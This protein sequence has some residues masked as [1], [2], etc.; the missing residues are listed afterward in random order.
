MKD[1]SMINQPT[2]RIASKLVILMVFC[3]CLWMLSGRAS[4][5][6]QSKLIVSLLPVD[7]TQLNAVDG[8]IP[9]ELRCADA[10]LSSPRSIEKLTCIIK[11]NTNRFITASTV[12]IRIGIERSG[13]I[14]ELRSYYT[15]DTFLQDD[16]RA[17][18]RNNRIPPGGEH[19][20]NE[21]PSSF[22]DGVVKS[23][24][25]GI[26]YVDFGDSEPVRLNRKG[27]QII[28]Q[29]REGASKYKS[30]L[31]KRYK[32]NGKSI[33]AI[34]TLLNTD[35]PSKE[36]GLTNSNEEKGPICSGSTY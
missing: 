4:S 15:L 11:N 18:H 32:E 20:I 35:A 21:L 2:F 3:V 22:S 16:F 36:A 27:S 1:T 34:V 30:W 28:G 5:I 12:E 14:L 24:A 13:T 17:D 7:V 33:G 8:V 25:V 6:Q 31:S 19:A 26:D 29:M 9:V 23:I 10:E